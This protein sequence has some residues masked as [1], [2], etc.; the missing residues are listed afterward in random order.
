MIYLAN[1]KLNRANFEK[2]KGY[3]GIFSVQITKSDRL[4]FKGEKD[5]S[6][7]IKVEIMDIN[8][9]YKQLNNKYSATCFEKIDWK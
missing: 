4:V 7:F 9:H 5:K 1:G 6:G 8:G 3:E 2:L